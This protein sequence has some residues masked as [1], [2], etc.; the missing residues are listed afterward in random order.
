MDYE[1]ICRRNKQRGV[2][3][4]SVPF[5]SA[6]SNHGRD[7]NCNATIPT[8]DNTHQQAG[9]QA[10]GYYLQN[11]ISFIRKYLKQVLSL[12]QS[13]LF[14]CTFT[15]SFLQT[16]LKRGVQFRWQQNHKQAW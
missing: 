8:M 9:Q 3:G 16:R 11:K 4:S 15:I 6:I 1:S 2:E 5:T 13:C 7:K 10:Q 14:A 12:I